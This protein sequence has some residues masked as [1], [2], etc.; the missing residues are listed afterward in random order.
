MSVGGSGV[1]G[2]GPGA[3]A[4]VSSGFRV[5]STPVAPGSRWQ[6]AQLTHSPWGREQ[7][8]I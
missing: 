7:L 2:Q 4:G 8:G 5:K 1:R 3:R 6:G